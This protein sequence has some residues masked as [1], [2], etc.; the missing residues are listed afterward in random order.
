MRVK[1]HPWL[2]DSPFLN[3]KDHKDFQ[4]IIGVYRWLIF[5]GIFDLSYDIF[6]LS[7]FSDSIWLDHLNLARRMFGYLKKYPK[8]GYEINPQPM[9]IDANYEKVQMKYYFGNQYA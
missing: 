9:T 1:E 7:R 6:S 4:N 3:D 5:A 8:I 2:D